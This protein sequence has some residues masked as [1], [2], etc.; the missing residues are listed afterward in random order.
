MSGRR[1]EGVQRGPGGS[2]EGILKTSGLGGDFFWILGGSG[3]AG[4]TP[5]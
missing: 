2:P 5:K 3:A 4:G 1:P